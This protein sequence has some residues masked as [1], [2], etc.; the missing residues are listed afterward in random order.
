MQKT[1]KILLYGLQSTWNYGCEAIVRGTL[2]MLK[3]HAGE[4]KVEVQLLVADVALYRKMFQDMQITIVPMRSK[5]HPRY[6]FG[7]VLR[8][9]GITCSAASL[10]PKNAVKNA[11]LAVCIGGDVFDEDSHYLRIF[12]DYAERCHV[13]VIYWGGSFPA[14]ARTKEYTPAYREYLNSLKAIFVRDPASQDFLKKEG[15]FRNVHL[16]PDPAFSMSAKE[17]DIPLR[18]E[19]DELIIGLNVSPYSAYL[20]SESRVYTEAIKKNAELIQRIVD[21][22]NAG[23]LLIPHVFPQHDPTQDDAAWLE[24]IYSELP[25]KYQKKVALLQSKIGAPCSKGALKQCDLLISARMHCCVAAVSQNIPTIFLG[26]SIKAEGMAR[27]VYDNTEWV[28]PVKDLSAEFLIDKIR[29]IIANKEML[30]RYLADKG[31][32]WKVLSRYAEI[33]LLHSAQSVK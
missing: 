10:V 23:I 25:E 21:E 17:Y 9:L 2:Q 15:V 20:S 5:W 33:T 8:K 27:N 1:I 18:R 30:R 22:F 19:K 3:E 29:A 4:Q 11:N 14:Y 32:K 31:K 28:I 13:P 24:Q 12:T 7:A 16:M 6:L 26:Y